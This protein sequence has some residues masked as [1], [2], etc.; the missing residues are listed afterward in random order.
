[1]FARFS[2]FAI[3][4]A[5]G[6]IGF[7][8]AQTAECSKGNIAVEFPTG[9]SCQEIATA[10]QISLKD[11]ESANTGVDCENL[12]SGG[13]LCIPVTCNGYKVQGGDTCTSIEDKNGITP[14][15]FQLSNPEIDAL[16]NNLTPGEVK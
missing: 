3:V 15:A 6:A 2:L 8:W 5:L 7:S 10:Y 11:L 9:M 1:M 4:T 16:C 13:V 14:L 12:S